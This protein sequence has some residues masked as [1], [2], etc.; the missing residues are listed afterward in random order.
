MVMAGVNGL[1]LGGPP[2]IN[3][4]YIAVDKS[5]PLCDIHCFAA[6]SKDFGDQVLQTGRP[7]RFA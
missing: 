2:Q 4:C 5:Q 1:P 3:V 6:D 7:W